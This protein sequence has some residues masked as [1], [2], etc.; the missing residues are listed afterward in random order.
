MREPL[1]IGTMLHVRKDIPPSRIDYFPTPNRQILFLGWC[2]LWDLT[3]V[4]YSDYM[5]YLNS[6]G[7]ILLMDHLDAFE[8]YESIQ[9]D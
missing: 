5:R 4:N 6:D 1:K 9:D 7:K 3:G 8:Y 2:R